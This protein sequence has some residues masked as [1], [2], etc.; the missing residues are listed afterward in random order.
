MATVTEQT[1]TVSLERWRV[2]LLLWE[3]RSYF[4]W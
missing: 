1:I 4:Y 2:Y 3:G